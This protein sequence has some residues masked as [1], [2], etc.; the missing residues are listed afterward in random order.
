M[1][2]WS[3]KQLK[4]MSNGGNRNLKEF[5]KVYNIPWQPPQHKYQTQ[6][7]K[8]YREKLKAI[9]EEVEL[10]EDPPDQNNGCEVIEYVP[11]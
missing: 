3:V 5:L 1:D 11:T 8:Y 2:S 7:A 9:V 6:A 4:Y 10:Q